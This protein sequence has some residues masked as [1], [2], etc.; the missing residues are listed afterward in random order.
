MKSVALRLL[1]FTVIAGSIVAACGGGDSSAPQA[2]SVGPTRPVTQAPQAT[3]APPPTATAVPISSGEMTASFTNMGAFEM[4][5]VSGTGRNYLDA[6][7]DYSIAATLDGQ[8]DQNSG[9][10]NSW[11][12]SHDSTVWTFK[13]RNNVAFHNGDKVTAKDIH[14]TISRTAAPNSK[15]ASATPL[16]R[17][18]K[19]METPDD[20]TLVVTLNGRN[21]FWGPNNLSAIGTGGAPS[22]V[23][24]KNYIEAKGEE[25]ANR[26]PVG[27]GVY[28]FKSLVLDDRVNLEALE[29][30]WLVGAPRIKTLVYRLIP[31][32]T[33][34]LALLKTGELNLMQISRNASK[35]VAAARNLRVVERKDSG[36]GQFIGVY[37]QFVK[38]YPGYGKNPLAE[39]KVRQALFWYGVD[40]ASL[41]KNFLGGYGTPSMETTPSN[42]WNP[43]YVRNPVVAYDPVKAKALLAEAGFASGF[44]LD[45]LIVPRPA[46][47]EGQ[48]IME[49]IASWWEGLGVKVTR[50]PMQYENVTSQH[51][52]NAQ[53]ASIWD[54]PTISGMFF[55]ANSYIPSLTTATPCVAPWGAGDNVRDSDTE[56]CTLRK[57]ALE[58]ASVENYIKG[59]KAVDARMLEQAHSGGFFQLGELFGVDSKVPSGWK[60]GPEPYSYRIERAAALR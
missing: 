32:E 7:Y 5:M 1:A 23:E 40:R 15:R 29:R 60:I 43:A 9:L 34:A 16:R 13:V 25:F 2:T 30:H 24:P 42:P 47:P 59:Q 6:M 53:A 3:S 33:T 45:L 41:V 54:R 4:L 44:Q 27:S 28:K 20:Y 11:T 8:L 51:V 36:Y 46:L 49:A 57:A 50:K 22:Y 31:E 35:E 56:L 10:V 39:T 19:A 52:K 58:P 55:L 38:E 14:S 17:D 21:I 37:D 48:Q 12:A 26:N 18:I